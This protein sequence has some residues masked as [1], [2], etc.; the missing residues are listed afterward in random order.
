LPPD[1]AQLLFDGRDTTRWVRASDGAAPIG[2]RILD[3][4][5]LE[6]E[7]GS[8]DVRSIN[9]ARDF[10]LHLEFWLPPTPPEWPDQSRSN[11]GVYLQ[12]RYEVQVLDSFGRPPLTRDGAGAIYGIQDPSANA[13]KP[14][15]TWQWYDVLFRAAQFGADGAKTAPAR[16]SLWWNGVLVHDALPV[17]GPT[18]G[19]APE[20]PEGGSLLL[21]DHGERV[22]FRN[23]WIVPLD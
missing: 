15:A 7:P 17:P 4:G 2:W 22:R 5:S 9:A 13:A 14:V 21:Q 18:A 10:R 8:G 1:G 20:S 12:G 3:D 19:G 11:S 6:V 23:I 16:V